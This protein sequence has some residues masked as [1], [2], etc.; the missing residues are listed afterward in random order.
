MTEP[1]RWSLLSAMIAMCG[2]PS[3]LPSTS[4]S[5]FPVAPQPVEIHLLMKGSL[6]LRTLLAR[7]AGVPK[8]AAVMGPGCVTAFRAQLH[9]GDGGADLLA[10][11][12][13]VNLQAAALAVFV[14]Q[15]DGDQAAV[16]RRSEPVN[17]NLLALIL[18]RDHRLE[19]GRAQLGPCRHQNVV[20]QCEKPFTARGQFA[21]KAA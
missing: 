6:G 3:A 20:A 5:A 18:C 10:A 16:R 8:S 17:E 21:P 14:G 1:R 11:G 9:A 7:I 4:R 19:S 2:K 12:D 15:H 13:V